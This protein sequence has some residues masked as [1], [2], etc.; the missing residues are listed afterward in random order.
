MRRS[1]ECTRTVYNSLRRLRESVIFAGVPLRN[2]A[3]LPTRGLPAVDS[4][5]P[6]ISM[7]AL[8]IFCVVGGLG[9]IRVGAA[10][11]EG[12]MRKEAEAERG[13]C[14]RQEHSALR[15][16]V[17]AHNAFCTC[18]SFYMA[19]GLLCSAYNLRYSVW[20]NAY[21]EEEKSMAHYIY[22]FYMSKMV[23]FLD[24]IIMLLKRNVRQVTVLHVYHHVSVAIIIILPRTRI[25]H[26]LGYICISPET[27]ISAA[28]NSIVHVFMYLYYFLWALWTDDMKRKQRYLFWGKYLTQMQMLQ[29]TINMVQAMYSI[30]F[31]S[32]YPQFLCKILLGY[33][34]SLLILF[35]N[36]Y[37]KKY[38]PPKQHHH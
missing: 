19:Y 23:E 2:A 24:T 20:G 14:R 8:Y 28:L 9:A 11:R 37:T 22:V 6:L 5:T 27:Y 34:I 21:K 25:T 10:P 32:P 3:A 38:K 12:S 7:L 15:Y 26:F 1:G 35:Y 13:R 4:P 33:M 29:F 17:L 30:I 16:L 18:L 36:F 31:K